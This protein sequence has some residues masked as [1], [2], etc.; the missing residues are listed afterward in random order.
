MVVTWLF[1]STSQKHKLFRTFA[2][3]NIMRSRVKEAVNRKI[4]GYNCA[5]AVACTYCDLAG[6]DEETM[7]NV[8]N[9]FGLG[10]GCTEGT[11]GSLVGAGVVLGLVRKDKAQSMKEMK[12]IMGKFKE[13]NCSTI[14]KELK[15]IE[16]KKVLR[17]CN[18]CVA[19]AA[20]FL[21]AQ[22]GE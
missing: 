8:T 2:E 16:T 18:D 6:M 17:A 12:I 19:D 13:R 1:L 3:K 5:Q 14:C 15:G 10:M 21:E 20:E 4:E 22:I 9:A 11:C 7:K